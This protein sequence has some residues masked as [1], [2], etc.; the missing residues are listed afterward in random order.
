MSRAKPNS[1]Y[2]MYNPIS[3]QQSLACLDVRVYID[4]SVDIGL[5]SVIKLNTIGVTIVPSFN[6][7]TVRVLSDVSL[8]F[9]SHLETELIGDDTSLEAILQPLMIQV[10]PNEDENV[11][12]LSLGHTPLHVTNIA[13]K[14]HT[15]ALEDELFFNSLDGQNTLVAIKVSSIFLNETSNPS[16]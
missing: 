5:I 15:N 1:V 10:F 13:V 8:D 11:L 6:D 9:V 12:T 7:C 16:R 3:I 2:I 4:G 14:E